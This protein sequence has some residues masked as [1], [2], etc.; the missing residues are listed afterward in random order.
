MI[1]KIISLE[2][3]LFM[4][5]FI[6]LISLKSFSFTAIHTLPKDWYNEEKAKLKKKNVKTISI[7]HREEDF[8]EDDYD[9]TWDIDN[10][11]LKGYVINENDVIISIP[12]DNVLKADEDASFMFS[13]F[14]ED[15]YDEERIYEISSLESIKNLNLL[16]TK[17]VKNMSYMFYG[18]ENLEKLDVSNFD[19]SNVTDMSYM[20]YGLKYIKKLDLSSFNA[21]MVQ[22]ISNMFNGMQNIEYID[23]SN[24]NFNTLYAMDWLFFNCKK[25][26]D[27]NIKNLNFSSANKNEYMF[28][29]CENITKIDF[30]GVKVPYELKHMFSNIKSKR[31]EIL[32]MDTKHV[33]NMQGLFLDSNNLEYLDIKCFDTSNVKNMYSMFNG[34]E[35][36]EY[37]DLSNFNTK[38]VVNMDSMFAY[39]K[40]LKELDLSNFDTT[41]VPSM[42]T[43]FSNCK[44]L[45]ILNLSKFNTENVMYIH[46]MFYNLRSLEILDISNFNVEKINYDSFNYFGV[47]TLTNLKNIRINYNILN[48]FK[49]FDVLKA[50]D[51]PEGYLYIRNND[52]LIHFDPKEKLN[53]P[54]MYIKPNS[55]LKLYDKYDDYFDLNNEMSINYN[56]KYSFEGFYEDKDFTKK[57]Y[58]SINIDK[59]DFTI[60]IKTLPKTFKITFNTNGGTDVPSQIV[61]YDEKAI[62]PTEIPIKDLYTFE[63]W[64]TDNIKFYE[65]FDFNKPITNDTEIYA[66]Y[67]YTG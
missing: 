30:S 8:D 49:E 63:G 28:G 50:W 10:K 9:A 13:F 60:Y 40:K 61:V 14:N 20:F 53:I 26:K 19:T 12:E 25:L 36:I 6:F 45:K 4:S 37:L 18:N 59:N 21:Y 58:N 29:E 57:I 55:T 34:L 39:M 11:G 48:K 42:N 67:R 3:L 23:L 52:Y 33:T 64:Y 46:E 22:T 2:F 27:V 54:D 15:V 51:N 41:N 38:N 47:E 17:E 66:K 44:S 31:L 32:N 62:K 65:E 24:F 7:E 43:M 56:C 5:I 1:K 35:N 16:D